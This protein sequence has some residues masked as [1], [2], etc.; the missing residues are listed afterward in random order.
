MFGVVGDAGIGVICS[1][2]AAVLILPI[3]LG[4]MLPALA[5]AVLA[6][7]LVQ[8]DGLLVIAG[9]GLALASL[10]LLVLSGSLVVEAVTRLGAMLGLW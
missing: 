6:F 1:L 9:Y 3:P 7:S 8:R 5:I 4:N 2:L 10:A